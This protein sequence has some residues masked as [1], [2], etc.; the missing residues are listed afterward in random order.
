MSN[1]E[2]NEESSVVVEVG[3]RIETNGI[4]YTRTFILYH[5]RSF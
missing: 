4:I 2:L 3:D 1:I 5:I